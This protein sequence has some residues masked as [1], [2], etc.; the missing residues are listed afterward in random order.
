MAQVFKFK[1][2]IWAGSPPGSDNSNDLSDQEE[3]KMNE[4]GSP[5]GSNHSNDHYDQE[6]E[7]Q[8]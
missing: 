5:P 8:S 3:A 1:N 7:D 2:M 4:A 6:E